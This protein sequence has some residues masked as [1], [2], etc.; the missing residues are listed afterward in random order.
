M[1]PLQQRGRVYIPADTGT[2]AFTSL[3]KDALPC[4]L[5]LVPTPALPPDAREADLPRT[6]LLWH[7]AYTMPSPA[8]VE[9]DGDRWTV[10]AG[11]EDPVKGPYGTVV[12]W[13][14]D[15]AQAVL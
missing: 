2:G 3:V 14:A 6:R 10:R 4:R 9:I 7:A 13:R 5:T 11:T 1:I 15:V 8:Q 12:Y